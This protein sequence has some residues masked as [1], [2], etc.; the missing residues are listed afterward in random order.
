[1]DWSNAPLPYKSDDLSGNYICN[2]QVYKIWMLLSISIKLDLVHGLQV[3]LKV[4]LS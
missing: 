3:Y 4:K 1:M 2:Q